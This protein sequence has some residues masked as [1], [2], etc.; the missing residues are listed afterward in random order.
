[1]KYRRCLECPG[2]SFDSFFE[3][4]AYQ[5]LVQAVR[6]ENTQRMS[7][8]IRKQVSSTAGAEQFFWLNLQLESRL[9]YT[10]TPGEMLGHWGA[11]MDLANA[12]GEDAT[13][14]QKAVAQAFAVLTTCERV[15]E[16]A[17]FCLRLRDGY[18]LHR[19]T[20]TYWY[21]RG[22]LYM[23]QSR[24]VLG[25]DA[26][27]RA[28]Q[29]F[30]QLPPAQFSATRGWISSIHAHLAIC[31]VAN[32]LPETAE[33]ELRAAI[34]SQ[35]DQSRRPWLILMGD[36]ELALFR[37]AFSAART[38]L[39][40]ARLESE[41]NGSGRNPSSQIAMELIAA[42]IARAEGNLLG[43]QHFASRALALTQQHDLPLSRA[44]VRRI[45][46]GAER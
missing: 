46:E 22:L 21:N 20:W 8:I 1:M 23:L 44:R 17:S 2:I 32:G 29:M 6:A 5:Q 11:V 24:Y 7:E 27:T 42:R 14:R 10:C 12:A 25:H 9:R 4:E 15:G 43:F 36:A 19:R 3:T 31:A 16:V 39:Q 45:M 41:A 34:S 33:S 26:F 18:F 35:L 38:A 40:L 37:R 30:G 28:L 13:L